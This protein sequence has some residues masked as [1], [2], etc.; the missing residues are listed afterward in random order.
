MHDSALRHP[1]GGTSVGPQPGEDLAHAI[2]IDMLDRLADRRER[3][4][5]RGQRLIV[6]PHE[7]RGAVDRSAQAVAEA[8]H[9]RE[10]FGHRPSAPDLRVSEAPQARAAAVRGEGATRLEALDERDLPAA[11]LQLERGGEPP[12]SRAHDDHPGLVHGAA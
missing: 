6:A 1:E 8:L 9:G 3:L 12:S 10:S 7:P 5:D 11:I 2:R 4:S